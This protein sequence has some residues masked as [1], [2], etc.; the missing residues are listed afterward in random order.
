[1]NQPTARENLFDNSSVKCDKCGVKVKSIT[2]C[3]ARRSQE[4]T[5]LRDSF[6][7]PGA[8]PF[9]ASKP[10]GRGEVYRFYSQR[11][12]KV[13]QWPN[14]T[15]MLLFL[16]AWRNGRR[17]GYRVTTES[18]VPRRGACRFESYHAHQ[19]SLQSI[20]K[21]ASWDHSSSGDNKNDA[22]TRLEG[23]HYPSPSPA[24]PV[25]GNA[26]ELSWVGGSHPAG[27]PECMPF[28]GSPKSHW[29]LGVTLQPLAGSRPERRNCL[30]F[31]PVP[32]LADTLLV[33]QGGEARESIL[34]SRRVRRNSVSLII[35]R[36]LAAGRMQF[37]ANGRSEAPAEPRTGRRNRTEK[38][39]ETGANLPTATHNHHHITN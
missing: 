17:S 34:E 23:N 7:Q 5:F 22:E 33:K 18:H 25:R 2:V 10:R 11:T 37:K 38:N 26:A 4:Q 8:A 13:E 20:A 3:R 15:G 31:R 27:I 39:S 19:L 16:S 1:M 35:N 32:V 30:Q 12:G 9:S 28:N 6:S 29:I 21:Q 36:T 24:V 14:T